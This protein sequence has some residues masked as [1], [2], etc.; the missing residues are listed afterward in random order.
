[1]ALSASLPTVDFGG[2]RISF[3]LNGNLRPLDIDEATRQSLEKRDAYVL[4]IVPPGTPFS[5][6]MAVLGRHYSVWRS[7]D[8]ELVVNFP[9]I[10]PGVTNRLYVN[11]DVTTNNCVVED[12]GQN[13]MG[14]FPRPY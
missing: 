14:N 8:N 6:A 9:I 5:N 13:W 2:N 11:F 3:C 10:V 12:M 7:A 1:M 4:S